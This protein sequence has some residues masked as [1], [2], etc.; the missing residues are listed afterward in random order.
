M[1]WLITV[2][3]I[4]VFLAVFGICFFIL[5][6]VLP[7]FR[8][9][10]L[11]EKGTVALG[12]KAKNA[13]LGVDEWGLSPFVYDGGPE[14]KFGSLGGAVKSLPLPLP[15]S[16][17]VTAFALD[18][19]R[20]RLVLGLNDGRVGSVLVKF[21]PA[22]KAGP[23][24]RLEAET[25]Q[26]VGQAGVPVTAVAYGDGGASK[27][28]AALQQ[29]P[30]GPHLNVVLIKEK[31]SLMGKPKPAVAGTFDL[32]GEVSGKVT[33]LLSSSVGDSLLVVTERGEVCYFYLDG[34]KL[35]LRQRFMP[36]SDLPDA[37]LA[38]LDY[39]SGSVSVVASSPGGQHRVFSLYNQ[40][41]VG[42]TE[43]QEQRLFG[44]T[45]RFPDLPGGAAFFAASQRNKTIITGTGRT[46]SVRYTTTTSV[47]WEK[48]LAFETRAVVLDGKAS[49]LFLLDGEGVAHR[50]SM[51]DPHP[52]AG[53]NAFFGKLWYEGASEPAFAWQSTG[54]S[55]DFEP[56]LSLTPLIVGSL[57][58]TFFALL[59]AVPL[60]LLAAVYS[61]CFL[62]ARMKQVVKPVM[63]L[64]SSLPSVVLGFLAGI[65]LAPILDDRVPSVLLIFVLLPSMA[66]LCGWLWN[67]LPISLRSRFPDGSEYW[68]LVVPVTLAVLIGWHLGPWVESWA[69]VVKDQGTGQAVADFRLWWPKVTGLGFDQRNSL[70]VGFMMGFAVIPVIFTIADD[71]LTNVPPS[72]KAASM[73]LGATRWQ[74][75]RTVVL[76]VASAGLFS[77]VM[78]GFGRAVGETMIVVMATGN[79][80]VMDFFNAFSGMRTLSANIA[81]ELP[82]AAVHS[83]HFRTLFL[84]AMIL[85]GL[86]FVL[87]TAAELMRQRLKERYKI[88]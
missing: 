44:E 58:G 31:R 1:T 55:D 48:T 40:K 20:N 35:E 83:T 63:E 38:R 67:R 34:G 70:V 54:G 43:G 3:G 6:E 18:T 5:A 60:A 11:E 46:V 80:P 39:V 56:K 87:N 45:K 15:E 72:L 69:F 85:F 32:S 2:G 33:Q 77:A 88:V 42:G 21:A 36:F 76:P 10:R 50:F 49:Y 75:V 13:L 37:T 68:L 86:T 57:K 79:T 16:A 65:W 61:G 59:F 14:V 8:G 24:P 81:V 22:T 51:E 66:L 29:L 23:E 9:A 27:L 30:D 64:M 12:S 62:P 52:E 84:G 4:A 47:R 19:K 74:V 41:K 78:I 28:I 17:T 53:W 25:F 82:E 71:A 7:L 26:P 73:A